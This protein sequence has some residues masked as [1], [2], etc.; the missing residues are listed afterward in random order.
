M[1]VIKTNILYLKERKQF[2]KNCVY[3]FGLFLYCF[4]WCVK[5][6][7]LVS[8]QHAYVFYSIMRAAAGKIFYD[9]GSGPFSV[10]HFEILKNAKWT[11]FYHKH[12]TICCTS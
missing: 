5:L 12:K 7:L 2:V 1:M 10:G 6:V 9:A 11:L 4:V 8:V 3:V